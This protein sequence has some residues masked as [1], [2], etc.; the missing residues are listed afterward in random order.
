MKIVISML[1]L[2][3]AA[4]AAAQQVIYDPETG[5]RLYIFDNTPQSSP[6]PQSNVN[7]AIANPAVAD[8]PGAMDRARQNRLE[9]ENLRLQNELLRQRLEKERQ[10]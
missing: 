4:P 10:E 8:I 6:L 1:A 7:D 9:A 3:V 5:Q 2:S